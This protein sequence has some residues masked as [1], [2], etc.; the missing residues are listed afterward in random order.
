MKFKSNRSSRVS[1]VKLQ[2][3][4]YKLTITTESWLRMKSIRY[5]TLVQSLSQKN[6]LSKKSQ[7]NSSLNP[8][9][10]LA[11]NLKRYS[12]M[13]V[14]SNFQSR[15]VAWSTSSLTERSM[16]TSFIMVPMKRIFQES[17]HKSKSKDNSIQLLKTFTSWLKS[18]RSRKLRSLLKSKINRFNK[19]L[20]PLK[21]NP[22]DPIKT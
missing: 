9:S 15:T 3:L 11:V 17:F 5:N 4:L 14:L 21:F 16:T 2:A 7:L 12:S 22:C 20:L 13:I 8:T 1:Q 6:S 10:N 19:M 18:R